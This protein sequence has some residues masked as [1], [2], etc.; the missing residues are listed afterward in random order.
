MSEND[1]FN[2]EFDAIKQQVAVAQQSIFERE[3][4]AK[5]YYYLLSR[6]P[7]L[8][9][10]N[11]DY[12]YIDRGSKPTVTKA[13]NGWPIYNYGNVIASG[14][15]ELLGILYGQEEDDDEGGHGTIVQQYTDVAYAMVALAIELGWPAVDIV[16]GFYPM[17]RMAWIAAE[18]A[19]YKLHKFDPSFEDYAIKNW[20]SARRAG[21]LYPPE[22]PF[23]K[24][25]A[26]P[27]R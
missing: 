4:S 22:K 15:Y 11:T 23:M 9:I 7:Y 6:Y 16:S 5:E 17:Q 3:I 19:D 24:P 26:S 18:L 25:D 21:K 27:R 2:D 1:D 8:E 20:E 13:K 14:C 12:P 10:C